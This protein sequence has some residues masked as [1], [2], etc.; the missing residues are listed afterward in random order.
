MDSGEWFESWFDEDYLRLYAHRD[1]TEAEV[2]VETA[3][4]VAPELA[5]GPVLD[6]ACGSGRHLTALRRRNPDAFGLDLSPTLLAQAD[7]ALR[8]WLLRGDMRRIP[9]RANAL[10][11]ICM[12]FTPFGYFDDETN[13]ALLMEV[14]ARLRPGGVLWMDYLNP[15]ALRASLVERESIE[16]NGMRADIV[17]AF[18]GNRLVKRIRIFRPE[19]A[20]REAEENV[21]LYEPEEIAALAGEWGLRLRE[22]IGSYAGAPFDTASPRWIGV[23]V[24]AG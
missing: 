24:K 1:G 20:P 5:S 12:W 15:A 22:E 4:R 11:A 6:L 9:V 17:R 13:R 3:L 2:A 21:R 23:F 19:E 8:P 7:P 14:S 18:E 10:A 16:R